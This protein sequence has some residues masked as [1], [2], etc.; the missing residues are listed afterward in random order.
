MARLTQLLGNREQ[1]WEDNL[2]KGRIYVYSEGTMY[3]SFC[4]GYCWR[5]P[6]CG[7]AVIE[8]WGASGSGAQMCCCGAGLPG[9]AP[10]YVKKCI[11]V[12]PSNYVCG[13]VGRSCN[14]SSALCFRGCSEAT[15]AYWTGCA[16]KPLFND[17]V[18]PTFDT[19]WKGNNPWGWGNN[20]G[21]TT[22]GAVNNARPDG[23]N[24]QKSFNDICQVAGATSGCLCS[25]GGRGGISFCMDTKSAYSCFITGYFCGNRVGPGHNMCDTGNSACGRICNW[26]EQYGGF[27]ACGYGGDL[28]CCG[29][30]SCSD[31]LGCLSQCPCQF[32]Y[33]VPIA[34]G[35]FADEGAML[36]YI[37]DGDTPQASWSGSAT[38][39]QLNTL[40]NL[41]RS[42]SY[43]GSQQGCW[44]ND[45]SCGCYEMQGCMSFFPYG[46]PGSPAMPCPG[47]RD[48]AGRGGMG[49]V[50]IK[51]QPTD[52]G[53]TY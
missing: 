15:C 3:T 52:G 50:R 47:V 53:A 22:G 8:L 13:Y 42:P 25:Q 18:D 7:K 43:T 36:T 2:E 6:G 4:N 46:V 16:P 24:N 32:M 34:A 31:F 27:M 38:M 1:A 19:S 17:G 33:H 51:Y 21:E 40:S 39:T 37:T 26:C 44:N 29:M 14:N 45:R 20:A 30:W 48:H 35:I 10:A 41:S 11:C 49:M 9:N 5:P 28:N 12:C 23:Y